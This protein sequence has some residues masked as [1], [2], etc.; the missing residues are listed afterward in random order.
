MKG[1]RQKHA[2]GSQIWWACPTKLFE[3]I[4]L[5]GYATEQIMSLDPLMGSDHLNLELLHIPSRMI[6]SHKSRDASAMHHEPQNK[7]FNKNL[8]PMRTKLQ[9]S[10]GR[11]HER[12]FYMFFVIAIMPRI[13]LMND[14]RYFPI[15]I[16]YHISLLHIS[17]LPESISHFWNYK[18]LASLFFHLQY[19]FPCKQN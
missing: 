17:R 1:P 7:Y 15:W 11:T 5:K 12:K 19:I 10:F 14:I 16:V 18:L 3:H 4:H 8:L 13:F 2:K 9:L 6:T